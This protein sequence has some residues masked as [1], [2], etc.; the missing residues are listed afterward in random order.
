M[1]LLPHLKDF[2]ENFASYWIVLFSF[3]FD[4]NDMRSNF[5]LRYIQMNL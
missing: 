2:H 5:A 1:Y 3:L 4:A